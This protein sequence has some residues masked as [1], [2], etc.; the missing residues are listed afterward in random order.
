MRGLNTGVETKWVCDR[1][2]H[3]QPTNEQMWN[4][5]VAAK[6]IDSSAWSYQSSAMWCRNCMIR[7][8][9]LP[10]AVHIPAQMKAAPESPLTL[11]QQ[12]RKIIGEIAR[13]EAET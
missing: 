7:I 5:A 4:V 11:E 2:G 13:E 9:V 3:T 12:L 8:G 6:S 1:C 10:P